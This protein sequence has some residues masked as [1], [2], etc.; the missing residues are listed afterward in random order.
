MTALVASNERDLDRATLVLR[1][2]LAAVFL[3]HGYQKMFV[4]GFSGVT[5]SFTY[6]GVP[7]P[8][9]IAPVICVLELVGG[10]ALLLGAFTRIVAVL[11][12][13]DMLGAII[14][15][16]ANAGF[17]APKGVELV[18]GNLGMLVAIALLGAGAYSVDAVM[19]RRRAPSP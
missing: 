6:M 3:V 19:A 11:L 14:F 8:G 10:A 13:C 15:V 9:V 18:L 16:H 12:A 1:L 7:I 2:V 5:T 4:Y 17:S